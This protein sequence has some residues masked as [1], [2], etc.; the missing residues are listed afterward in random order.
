MKNYVYVFMLLSQSLFAAALPSGGDLDQMDEVSYQEERFKLLARNAGQEYRR[1]KRETKGEAS[2]K[3]ELKSLLKDL[4]RAGSEG[5]EELLLAQESCQLEGGSCSI[6]LR[7][8]ILNLTGK[9]SSRFSLFTCTD[10]NTSSIFRDMK[11]ARNLAC[12]VGFLKPS[13]IQASSG[14]LLVCGQGGRRGLN[15]KRRKIL[16]SFSKGWGITNFI[17]ATLLR[18]SQGDCL[19]ISYRENGNKF[20]ERVLIDTKGSDWVN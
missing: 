7:N 19:L 3:K 17:G 9:K 1:W 6:F 15:I 10:E 18:G 2:V 8:A 5:H 4:K 13:Y 12:G 20:Q 11:Y 14:N 16:D